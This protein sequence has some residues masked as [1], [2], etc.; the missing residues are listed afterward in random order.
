MAEAGVAGVLEIFDDLRRRG[1]GRGDGVGADGPEGGDPDGSGEGVPLVGEVEVEKAFAGA[2]LAGLA[3]FE[4]VESGVADEQGGVGGAQHGFEV[5]GVLD[6]FGFDLPEAG[7]EDAR[8]D[9]GG[10][11]GGVEG[12]AAYAVDA[13]GMAHDE[14]DGA[15]AVARGDGAAGDDGELGR[16]GQGGDGDES[17]VGV[18]G[19]ELRGAFGGGVGGEDV[20]F[21]EA[22]AVGLV[23]KAPHQGCGIEEAD[24]G[25]A[26][27]VGRHWLV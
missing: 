15:H 19:G 16:E 5:G 18:G 25:N 10:A 1:A 2:A 4:R 26:E 11:G 13:V 20:A 9:G 6:E 23:L 27:A 21:G 8:V 22:L 12:D 24:G 3:I 17:D 14:K 7:E